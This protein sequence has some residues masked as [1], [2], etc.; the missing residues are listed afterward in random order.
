[1]VSVITT[2]LSLGKDGSF[3]ETKPTLTGGR[4]QETNSSLVKVCHV[5]VIFL[6]HQI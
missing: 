6:G 5:V 2:Y 1:M 3:A 4:K